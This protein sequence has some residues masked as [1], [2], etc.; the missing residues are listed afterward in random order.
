MMSK[1][2]N[3]LRRVGLIKLGERGREGRIEVGFSAERMSKRSL[4]KGP[5]LSRVTL[6]VMKREGQKRRKDTSF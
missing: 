1:H 3:D 6:G 5:F 4:I 2:N